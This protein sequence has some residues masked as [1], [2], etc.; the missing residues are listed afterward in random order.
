[1]LNEPIDKTHTFDQVADV[2]NLKTPLD[3][4]YAQTDNRPD[5]K[6]LSFAINKAKAQVGMVESS[7]YPQVQLKA[8]YNRNGQNL[9]MNNNPYADNSIYS[10][11]IIANWDIFDWGKTK[12]DVQAAKLQQIAL[13]N[14]LANLKTQ[15][16]TQILNAYDQAEVAYHN[17]S[18]SQTALKEANENYK[19]TNERYLNQLATSTDILDARTLLTQSESNYYG[20]IYGYCIA[21]ENLANAV[22][23]SDEFDY[24]IRF[25]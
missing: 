4:L 9:D 19:L 3:S 13:E 18:V 25:K 8:N 1:M 2:V 6:A 14:E 17:I 12:N 11:N 23:K 20:A 7:Y 5:I 10:L 16:K 22:G 21:L 24:L 15:S